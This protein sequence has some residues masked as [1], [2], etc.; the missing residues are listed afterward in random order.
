MAATKYTTLAFLQ[1]KDDT[2]LQPALKLVKGISGVSQVYYG[3]R[4]EDNT[5]V[6]IGIGTS[7][8]ISQHL[9]FLN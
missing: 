5:I 7:Y 8:P 3:R 4:I 9:A 2:N 6:D 1:L